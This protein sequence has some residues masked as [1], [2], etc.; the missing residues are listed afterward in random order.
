MPSD[1]FTTGGVN[2]AGGGQRPSE[3]A[4]GIKLLLL[5]LPLEHRLN[6]PGARVLKAGISL[7]LL[8]AV[9]LASSRAGGLVKQRSLLR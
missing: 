4:K 3:I 7:A 5:F 8:P 6:V 9:C 2:G 1:G